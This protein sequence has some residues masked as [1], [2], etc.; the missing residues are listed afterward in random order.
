MFANQSSRREDLDS[1]YEISL[2]ILYAT[3]AYLK[4]DLHK[5][6]RNRPWRLLCLNHCIIATRTGNADLARKAYDRLIGIPARR[7]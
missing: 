4:S 5:Q 3:D 2:H 1:L 7:S 6:D